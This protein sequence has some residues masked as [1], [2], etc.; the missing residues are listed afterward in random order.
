MAKVYSNDPQASRYQKTRRTFHDDGAEM[1]SKKLYDDVKKRQRSTG[2]FTGKQYMP[3]IPQYQGGREV[4]SKPGVST[5]KSNKDTV[6]TYTGKEIR[7]R[8]Q[9]KK[10]KA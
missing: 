9:D 10:L 1:I 4:I 2:K 7:K 6:T 5:S 3:V 8:N